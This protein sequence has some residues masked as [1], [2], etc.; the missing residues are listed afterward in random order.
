MFRNFQFFS[1][2]HIKS[3]DN[4][5]VNLLINDFKVE[6]LKNLVLEVSPYAVKY[7][8]DNPSS[9]EMNIYLKENITQEDIE[10]NLEF[11]FQNKSIKINSQNDLFYKELAEKL[12]IQ[13][14]EEISENW[15]I[16]EL[17]EAESIIFDVDADILNEFTTEF[18]ADESEYYSEKKKIFLM[19]H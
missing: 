15:E 5:F 8:N 12:Q 18:D 10:K 14:L 16:Y 3:D 4:D 7:F 2:P 19:K 6:C 13:S 1:S 17:Q 9:T 11:L